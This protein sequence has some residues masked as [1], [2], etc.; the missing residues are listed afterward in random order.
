MHGMLL[1]VVASVLLV[2]ADAGKKELSIRYDTP[3]IVWNNL[4]LAF[5]PNTVLLILLK[6]S[7]V[8]TEG[9]FSLIVAGAAA[10]FLAELSFM[11]S[12]RGGDFSLSQP[13]KAFLP[14]LAL[15][16]GWYFLNEVP[17]PAS[18]IGVG[19]CFCGA[20]MMFASEK[21]HGIFAP[22]KA[23]L[24]EPASRWM[25]ISAFFGAMSSC[26]QRMG[27]MTVDPL[28]FVTLVFLVEWIFFG[29]YLLKDRTNPLVIYSGDPFTL[30]RTGILWGVGMSIFYL[31]VSLTAIVNVYVVSQLQP[32]F[33]LFVGRIIFGEQAA[34]SRVIP[35]VL[36]IAGVIVVILSI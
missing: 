4:L 36:M 19:V 16:L 7:C 8:I 35:T 31:A 13:F 3:V 28:W 12:L 22:L 14:V 25:F 9:V 20:W 24:R 21:I 32:I 18:L 34:I 2:F 6:R 11:K 1:A 27:S 5:I 23:I 15:P 29:I 10:L 30:V 33:A 26:I 17:T